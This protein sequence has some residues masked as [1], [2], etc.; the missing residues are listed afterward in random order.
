MTFWLIVMLACTSAF[1]EYKIGRAIPAY[2][3]LA[4]KYPL[5]NLAG[6]MFLTYAI[7]ILFGTGGLIPMMGGLLATAMMVPYYWSVSFVNEHEEQVAETIQVTKDAGRGIWTFIK[8]IGLPFRII[9]GIT[10]FFATRG[11]QAR[12]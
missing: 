12:A 3:E 1:L 6:S 5:V 2:V 8:F 4:S 7:S 9:R 11:A 10:R